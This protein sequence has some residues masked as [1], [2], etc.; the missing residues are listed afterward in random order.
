[1]SLINGHEI[2]KDSFYMDEGGCYIEKQGLNIFLNKLEKK[3]MTSAK[4]LYDVNYVVTFRRA[5]ALQVESLVKSI[6]NKDAGIY[7]PVIIR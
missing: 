5:I 1:M 6:K 4:Y 2:F 7:C 3:M